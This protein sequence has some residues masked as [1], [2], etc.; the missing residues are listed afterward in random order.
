MTPAEIAA[1]NYDAALG[2][3]GWK[4][5]EFAI[6][7]DAKTGLEWLSGPDVDTTWAAAN[8]WV[9]NLTLDGGGWRMPTM[10]ELKGL[11]QNGNGSRNM[12]PLLKT[13]GWWIWSGEKKGNS[14]VWGFNFF[15]GDYGDRYWESSFPYERGFAVRSKRWKE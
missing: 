11:Y 4:E 5:I 15:D 9:E 3:M 6:F 12:T 7:F 1:A 14:A 10:S 8:K 13:T 2:P